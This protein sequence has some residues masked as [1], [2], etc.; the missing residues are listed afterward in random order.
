MTIRSIEEAL[1]RAGVSAAALTAQE[2]GSLDA[3]GYVLLRGAL[4]A[5]R[6]AALIETFERKFVPGHLWPAPREHGT[7]H[8]M[9]DNEPDVWRACL[10]PRVLAAVHHLL[11]R[12]FFLYNVQG[13]DPSPGFGYQGLHRD[14]IEPGDAPSVVVLEFLEP[15]GPANGATRVVPKSHLMPGDANV[16]LNL[17]NHPDEVVVEGAAGDALVFGG[18][19]VHSAMRNTDGAPRRTLQMDFRGHELHAGIFELRDLK[20]AA[21][22]VRYL[23]G[24]DD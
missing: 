8:A 21:P 20:D 3:E 10:A 9:L 15:F 11:R 7:R 6:C 1:A 19:L 17:A 2:R 5:E 14:W 12:R 18:R 22:E 13:R 4:E 16:F 23:L 24:Q